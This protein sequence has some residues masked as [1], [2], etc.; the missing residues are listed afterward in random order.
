MRALGMVAQSELRPEASLVVLVSGLA[1]QGFEVV[2]TQHTPAQSRVVVQ[3]LSMLD[4]NQRR[5]HSTQFV[6][7]LF[8]ARPADQVVVEYWE[9]DG[10]PSL[11]TIASRALIERAQREG[12]WT[13]VAKEFQFTNLKAPQ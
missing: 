12:D 6:I 8:H 4:P 13:I 5:I 1:S 11:R 2:E 9:R 10:T 3:D 7:P